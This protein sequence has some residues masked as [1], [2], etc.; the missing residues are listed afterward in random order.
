[1]LKK[2]SKKLG[3]TET[4]IKVV[5]FLIIIFIIGFGVKYFVF[6]K[7]NEKLQVF[8][9]TKQDSLFELSKIQDSSSSNKEIADKVVDYKQE[10]LDFNE[11]NFKKRKKTY[12]QKKVLT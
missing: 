2:F 12:P 8:D 6:Q 1:M 9:Y 3:F 10:V 7:E 4:E 11:I 5:L